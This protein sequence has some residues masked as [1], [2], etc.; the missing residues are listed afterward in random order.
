MV[1]EDGEVLTLTSYPM[2]DMTIMAYGVKVPSRLRQR[3][4]ESNVAKLWDWRSAGVV[5]G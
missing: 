5:V 2:P 1:W 3:N 4:Y